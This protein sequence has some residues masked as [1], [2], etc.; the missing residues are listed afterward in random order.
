LNSSAGAEIIFVN[1][2]KKYTSK[3]M[4]DPVSVNVAS[5]ID[6]QEVTRG[7]DLLSYLGHFL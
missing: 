7:I 1:V 5:L 6:L 4:F 3:N 2:Q